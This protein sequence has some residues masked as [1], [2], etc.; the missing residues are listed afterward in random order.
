ML[1]RPSNKM[2]AAYPGELGWLPIL[3][4]Y[5]S[6]SPTVSPGGIHRESIEME[7]TTLVKSV[8][9]PNR[10]AALSYIAIVSSPD[11]DTQNGRTLNCARTTRSTY[12]CRCRTSETLTS[13]FRMFVSGF[14]SRQQGGTQRRGRRIPIQAKS[15][16]GG[17]G[18]ATAGREPLQA[19]DMNVE[20]NERYILITYQ[21]N[22]Q[23]SQETSL[24]S[25]KL[26]ERKAK[27]RTENG[28][29]VR[30]ALRNF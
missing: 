26:P 6:S 19:R 28:P 27:R 22:Q 16:E 18:K 9:T 29:R 2:G 12:I 25:Y 11:V 13:T 24:A 23:L 20:A 3:S 10:A 7:S 1:G 14:I 21:K 4:I 17:K 30:Q 15:Q 8:G 5:S